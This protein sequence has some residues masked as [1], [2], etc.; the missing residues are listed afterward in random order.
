MTKIKW[1]SGGRCKKSLTGTHSFEPYGGELFF[2]CDITTNKRENITLKCDN[3][4]QNITLGTIFNPY[5]KLYDE[6]LIPIDGLISWLKSSNV[7]NDMLSS[8]VAAH[9][10]Q[11][12]YGSKFTTDLNSVIRLFNFKFPDYSIQ[13]HNN[14]GVDIHDENDK[15]IM[16]VFHKNSELAM[17][18]ALLKCLQKQREKDNE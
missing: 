4:Y 15:I 12:Y 13:L 18:I 6:N 16:E 14:E 1:K 10:E 3:C 7:G 5:S 9:S 8:M 11:V 17:C 2:K